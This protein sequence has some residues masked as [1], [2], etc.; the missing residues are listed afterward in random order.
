LLKRGETSGR[1]DDNL[2]SIQKRLKNFEEITMPVIEH[3]KAI[4]K[5]KIINSERDVTEVTEDTISCFKLPFADDKIV[6]VIGGPGSGKGMQCE[7]LSKAFEYAHISIGDVFREEIKNKTVLGRK[8]ERDLK[9]GVI[10][11]LVLTY[12]F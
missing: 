10:I 9:N 11:P 6:F 8:I 4:D 3:Y 5:I 7:M 2:E 12:L 1:L